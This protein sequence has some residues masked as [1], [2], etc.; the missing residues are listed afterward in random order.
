MTK[1]LD[2]M[3]RRRVLVPRRT[4]KM[5]LHLTEYGYHRSGYR[6]IRERKRARWT[7]AA[8]KIAQEN[9][10]VKTMLHYV[11][12]RP[13]GGTNYDLSLLNADGSR[14]R[15]YRKLRGWTRRAARRGK[16][17]RPG[18]WRAG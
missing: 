5:K 17:A 16:I 2:K 3:K 8:F 9:R 11:F 15:T 13:P 7:K 12:V 14:T 10:R 18:R 1:A 4:R 6:K